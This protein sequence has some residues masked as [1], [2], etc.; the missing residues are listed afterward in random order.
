[1]EQEKNYQHRDELDFREPTHQADPDA[2][3]ATPMAHHQCEV[4]LKLAAPS[5]SERVLDIA[6][7]HG[8]A[9]ATFAP[10]VAEVIAIDHDPAAEQRL[11]EAI[12]S[13]NVYFEQAEATDLPFEDSSFDMVICHRPLH[14]FGADLLAV[15]QE[16]N[17]V[18]KPNS[19]QFIAFDVLR[20]GGVD[21][22]ALRGAEQTGQVVTNPAPDNTPS[23]AGI[24]GDN[25]LDTPAIDASVDSAVADYTAGQLKMLLA[26]AM[27]MPVSQEQLARPGHPEENSPDIL[28]A[29][30]VTKATELG[31]NKQSSSN[32]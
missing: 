14:K 12:T 6:T 8:R 25:G 30:F 10:K 26:E 32:Q 17:R 7:E 31:G 29:V 23:A 28:A 1:M 9:T 27:L 2:A 19:G 11:A 22:V 21:S 20:A 24:A 15:L 18:L 13:G 4:M 3:V 16:V 5:G